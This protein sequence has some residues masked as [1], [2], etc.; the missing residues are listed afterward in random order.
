MEEPIKME[1]K[2]GQ[3]WKTYYNANRDKILERNKA[4]R[5]KHSEKLKEVCKKYWIENGDKIK[6]R[7]K[8]LIECPCCKVSVTRES[9]G[10]HKKSKAHIQKQNE[11]NTE[12]KSMDNV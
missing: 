3:F 7:R 1:N 2:N 8:M 5:E 10:R 12:I 11:N 9:Y 4:Y 6:E